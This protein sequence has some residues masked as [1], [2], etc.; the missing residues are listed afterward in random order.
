MIRPIVSNGRLRLVLV[1]LCAFWSNAHIAAMF[2]AEPPSPTAK[3]TSPRP[4]PQL[5]NYRQTVPGQTFAF[6]MVAI[7]GGTITIGSPTNEIGRDP[8]DQPQRQITVKPFWMAK[9]EVGWVEFLPYAWPPR[10]E[11]VPEAYRPGRFDKDGISHPTGIYFSVYR[12]RGERGFPAIGMSHFCASEYCRWLSKKTGLK[13][14]LPTE[15]EWEY[16]CRAGAVTAYFWGDDAAQARDYGWSKVTSND[17]THPF[18]RL[19]PNAFGLYDIIGNVAEWCQKTG[20][21]APAVA[22]GGAWSE[23]VTKLRSVARM[24]E[25]PEWNELDPQ[26]PQSIWWL[27]AA[28]FVGFRVVRVLDDDPYASQR[29]QADRQRN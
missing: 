26:I 14:R 22:R 17:T 23:P 12:E 16:A 15:E 27:S 28:D 3:P 25:T 2:A 21:N 18:G 7:P 5:R 24:I 20:T 11:I 6:E 1:L 9:Y 10:D 13:F 8:Y 19:K 4:A 29:E